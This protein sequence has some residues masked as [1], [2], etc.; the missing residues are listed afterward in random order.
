[1]ENERLHLNSFLHKLVTVHLWYQ[2]WNC[3][4]RYGKKCDDGCRLQSE[5]NQGIVLFIADRKITKFMR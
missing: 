2:V 1:M 3:H 4:W 5:R